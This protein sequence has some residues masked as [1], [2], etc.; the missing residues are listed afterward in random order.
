M[1]F[2]Y[3]PEGAEPKKWDYNPNRMMSPEAEAIERHTGMTFGEFLQK[4]GQG[5]FLAIHGL[6]YV[7]LK[8]E[9]PTLKFDEVQFCLDDVDFEP[10]D[11]DPEPEDAADPEGEPAVEADPKA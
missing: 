5:S 2:V 7:M 8:R 4:C 11:D 6:L 1:K 3:A 9:Y 10:D